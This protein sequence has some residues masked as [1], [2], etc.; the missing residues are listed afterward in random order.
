MILVVLSPAG[1]P[2]SDNSVE[3]YSV[4]HRMDSPGGQRRWVIVVFLM[5]VKSSVMVDTHG[6]L[7]VGHDVYSA[8]ITCLVR[9]VVVTWIGRGEQRR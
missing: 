6:T 3:L 5:T 8:V 2:V 4:H 1:Y 9:Y 7:C